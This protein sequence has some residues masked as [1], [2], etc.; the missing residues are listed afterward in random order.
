MPA[1]RSR[2]STSTAHPNKPKFPT[3]R[4]PPSRSATITASSAIRS[5]SAEESAYLHLLRRR[6]EPATH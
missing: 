4:L 2:I 6:A 5:R 1:C 3:H